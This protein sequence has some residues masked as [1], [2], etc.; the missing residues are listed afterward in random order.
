LSAAV[1]PAPWSGLAGP[2]L[3]RLAP[4]RPWLPFTVASTLA[5]VATL[6][7]PLLAPLRLAYE[8]P[9]LHVALETGTALIG[10][11]ATAIVVR[12]FGDSP[13]LDRLVIAAGLA[14]IAL[15]SAALAV[16]LAIEPGA[17][18][19]GIVALTGMLVGTL[20][21]GAGAFAPARRPASARR[22]VAATVVIVLAALA[23]A[24][25]PVELVLDVW[26]GDRRSPGA[27]PMR[28]LLT[29]PLAVIALQ[30]VMA[31]S[32]AVASVGLTARAVRAHDAFA[33]RLGLA[34]M[35]FAFSMVQYA[36]LPPVGHEWVHIGDVLRLLFCVVL[37]WAAVREVASAVAARAA[38]RERRRIARDLHDG[39]AQELAFIRR[40]AARL[41]GDPDAKEIVVAAERALRDSRWAIE[42]LARAPDEPLDR[43]LARH[44]A[45]IAARTGVAVTFS[46]SGS[47]DVGP[48]VSEALARILGEAVANAR[49]GDA[50]VV[51]VELTT[52]PL[53]L[54]V[55]DDGSGFDTTA[56]PPGFGLGGMRERAEL[57]GA[58][59][60]VR[61]DPG[62]GTEVAV[63]LR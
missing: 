17:G 57:V 61:S 20:L 18:P 38:A 54:R 52:D 58:E 42:R 47:A 36:L 46:T 35:F 5:L 44:A 1:R 33:R 48:E 30:L 50:S 10:L 55:I 63:E 59:L 37:L 8:A 13:R 41:A 22:A 21:V 11:V 29:Q 26:R 2:V 34:V 39:I 12:G 14:V 6:G 7:I 9:S 40:R 15:T 62:S 24:T 32:L 43:V 60:S 25:V 4:A 27:D 49:H 23:A 53:R 31:S 45:V 51:H 16:M 19:R 28:E 56:R 3:R